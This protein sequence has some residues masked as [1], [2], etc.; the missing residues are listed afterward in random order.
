MNKKLLLAAPLVVGAALVAKKKPSLKE[1]MDCA[2]TESSFNCV[3]FL[4]NYDGDTFTVTIPRIPPVFGFKVPVRVMHIDT[5]ELDSADVCEKNSAVEAK[6]RVNALL[7]SAKKIDLLNV[8]RD[9]YFRILA[10]VKVN[11]E[12]S[13]GALLLKEKLAVPYEGEEKPVTNWCVLPPNTLK[14]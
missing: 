6:S 10:E 2:R 13:L 3:T 5:A 8:K 14:K 4:D 11:D 12:F 1:D 7:K 9:K